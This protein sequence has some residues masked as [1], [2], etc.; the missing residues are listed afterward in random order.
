M[1]YWMRAPLEVES[2]LVKTFLTRQKLV[3]A[4]FLN[5]SPGLCEASAVA[6]NINTARV[7]VS[8]AADSASTAALR[9][10]RSDQVYRAS[11]CSGR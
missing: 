8:A 9:L 1:P 6:A 11:M 5:S 4:S 7:A 3:G 2:G 10:Q